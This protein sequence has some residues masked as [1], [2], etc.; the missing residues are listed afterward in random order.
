MRG[1]GD[2]GFPASVPAAAVGAAPE[3]AG[4]LRGDGRRP[5]L[6]AAGREAASRLLGL[7]FGLQKR[8]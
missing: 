8:F 4:F 1:T 6:H 7:P 3:A 5:C 2:A